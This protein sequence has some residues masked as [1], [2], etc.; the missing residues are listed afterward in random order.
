MTRN[1][2]YNVGLIVASLSISV[3]IFEIFLQ[4]RTPEFGLE[5]VG[6]ARV[7]NHEFSY[8]VKHN[9]HGFRG[10]EFVE[11]KQAGRDRIL[12]IG[13]SSV[14]G[15]GT[16]FANTIPH[17]L[18]RALNDKG[19]PAVEVYN[20]GV[21][22]INTT[23]YLRIAKL[24][25]RFD[26][27]LVLLGFS[28]DND[29]WVYEM[30]AKPFLAWSVAKLGAEVIYDKI[31]RDCPHDWVYH[32]KADPTYLRLACEGLID[33]WL[34]ARAYRK[35]RNEQAY[36]RRIVRRLTQKKKIIEN[37]LTIRKIFENTPLYV[38]IFPSKG[39]V[40]SDY[41]GDMRKLGYR[42]KGN[43]TIDDEVQKIL[44]DL[45]TAQDIEYIDLL[46]LVM[47]SYKSEKRKH[48]YDLDSHMNAFGHKVAAEAIAEAI[49]P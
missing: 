22:G 6:S 17:L 23:Q 4:V 3:A 27:D 21:P 15:V 29:T 38:V 16:D 14:Y 26:P 18:E 49:R 24:F 9:S 20:L 28:V 5:Y 10:R 36:Y 12:F 30:E 2:I 40:S 19:P 31:F 47:A 25:S 48:Y 41:F 44:G 33:P 7:E 42:F 34:I 45:L 13:D 43:E 8:V 32:Y 46:P 1:S 35:Q 39:Q 11:E 37:I